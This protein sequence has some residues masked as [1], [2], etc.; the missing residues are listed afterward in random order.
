VN[1]ERGYFSA[2]DCACGRRG[3]Q[4]L[5]LIG[6]VLVRTIGLVVRASRLP[7]AELVRQGA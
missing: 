7:A 1:R 4:P 3:R 2:T 6:M 5:G